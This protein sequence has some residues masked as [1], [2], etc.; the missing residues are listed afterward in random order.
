M[1]LSCLAHFA[2]LRLS[3]VG[4]RLPPGSQ[5]SCPHPPDGYLKEMLSVR[6]ISFGVNTSP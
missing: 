6:G 5:I 2:L 3:G 1:L 4:S